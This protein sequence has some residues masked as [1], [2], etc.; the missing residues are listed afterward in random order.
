MA[1]PVKTA[2]S[3]QK[4]LPHWDRV[5]DE[6]AKLI[7]IVWF[8]KTELHYVQ[9]KKVAARTLLHSYGIAKDVPVHHIRDCTPVVISPELTQLY[10]IT[11]P[12]FHELY[13]TE[14][15][16][17]EYS[18]AAE[19]SI[20]RLPS[21]RRTAFGGY[22]CFITMARFLRSLMIVF[23]AMVYRVRPGLRS[24]SKLH[25]AGFSITTR[26]GPIESWADVVCR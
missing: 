6:Q 8:P 3:V 22:G 16:N 15:L 14:W 26:H 23:Y 20:I 9:S 12:I 24:L 5:K 13:S 25:H 7:T 19:K 18:M 11:L 17:N 21:I 1:A 2:S 4:Q 10:L